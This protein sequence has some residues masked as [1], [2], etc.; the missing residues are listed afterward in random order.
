MPVTRTRTAVP[1]VVTRRPQEAERLRHAYYRGPTA[2]APDSP[3]RHEVQSNGPAL[4]DRLD[5]E[6]PV[7]AGSRPT[8]SPAGRHAPTAAFSP[9]PGQRVRA[10]EHQQ[11]AKEQHCAD[12]C[13]RAEYAPDHSLALVEATCAADKDPE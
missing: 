7:V 11:P 6:S 5:L 13:T 8:A 4:A 1:S 9:E 10:S 3:A 12:R 2:S